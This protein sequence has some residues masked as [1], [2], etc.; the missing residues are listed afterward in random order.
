[1]ADI[2][3]DADLSEKP[4]FNG[5]VKCMSAISETRSWLGD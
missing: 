4:F 5:L 1:M 3:A 2:W